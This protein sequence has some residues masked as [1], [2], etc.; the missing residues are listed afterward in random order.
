MAL[1]CQQ[2][3]LYKSEAIALHPEMDALGILP[4]TLKHAIRQ[5][6]VSENSCPVHAK[7]VDKTACIAATLKL[8]NKYVDDAWHDCQASVK[9][10][11]SL[12]MQCVSQIAADKYTIN[13]QAAHREVVLYTPP[14]VSPAHVDSEP[15]STRDQ[16]TPG[17]FFQSSVPHHRMLS[18]FP[19]IL[20]AALPLQA[21]MLG[22]NRS[23]IDAAKRAIKL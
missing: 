2:P 6:T 12:A 11:L 18:R 20:P 4:W 19:S 13:H 7:C 16:H 3:I 22:A 1:Q 9:N 17:P 8:K 14:L 10:Q 5:Y 23:D 15:T 21:L